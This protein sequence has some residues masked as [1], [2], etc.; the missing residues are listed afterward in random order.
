MSQSAL[1][2]HPCRIFLMCCLHVCVLL[3]HDCMIFQFLSIR[4]ILRYHFLI[5]ILPIDFACRMELKNVGNYVVA[6][7]TY[8]AVGYLSYLQFTSLPVHMKETTLFCFYRYVKMKYL[9]LMFFS[10]ISY[11]I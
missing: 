11:K 5:V 4:C 3:R 10:F 8:V 9:F 2:M 1:Y 6:M 7:V